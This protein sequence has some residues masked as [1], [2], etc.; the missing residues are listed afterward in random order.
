MK[1]SESRIKQIIKEEVELMEME[2]D[3][4][5]IAIGAG[6]AYALY[7]MFFGYDPSS[8]EEALEGVR[9]RLRKLESEVEVG[10]NRRDPFSPSPAPDLQKIKAK[11]RLAK[12]KSKRAQEQG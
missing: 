9:E 8:T 12:L 1:L 7:K 11:S 4:Y 3:P 6:A 10:D 5:S 2:I